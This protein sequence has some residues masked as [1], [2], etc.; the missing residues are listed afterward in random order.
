MAIKV[1]KADQPLEVGGILLTIYG[2]TSR[3]KTT[4]ALTARNPLLF[5][6]D[7]GVVRALGR[8]DV[9][10]VSSWTDDVAGLTP[11]DL[12]PYDTV[13][14]DTAGRMLDCLA[15]DI[16]NS[17]E[18]GMR[19]RDGGL[20]QNGF[21]SLKYRFTSWVRQIRATGKDV[22]V[23]CHTAETRDGEKTTLKV[24]MQGGAKEWLP[25]E[26]TV[27]GLI[28]YDRGRRVISFSEDLTEYG[29]DPVKLKRIAV[30]DYSDAQFVDFGA[31]LI[32]TIRSRLEEQQAVNGAE[33]STPTPEVVEEKAEPEATETE[34]DE[35]AKEAPV[36]PFNE[37]AE[38]EEQSGVDDTGEIHDISEGAIATEADGGPTETEPGADKPPIDVL[39]RDFNDAFTRLRAEQRKH[40]E[41]GDA[42]A[43]KNIKDSLQGLLSG[44]KEQGLTY[45]RRQK[46][47]RQA[48]R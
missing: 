44:A 2:K 46:T 18:P 27:M 5:D 4:L 40:H 30:P 13:I 23:I 31:K 37:N 7:G 28:D 16:I 8:R 12:A 14:I 1:T 34:T 33:P 21:G 43:E 39:I 11:A 22:I 3:G 42:E 41:S 26:S 35:L 32:S 15:N 47:F 38:T 9:V 48:R 25:Q 36:L 19:K 24:D 10:Q 6:F 45:D 17:G 20:T 29:K